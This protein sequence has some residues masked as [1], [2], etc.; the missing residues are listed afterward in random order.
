M[1]P[2]TPVTGH[3]VIDDT[4]ATHSSTETKKDLR[5]RLKTLVGRMVE[6]QRAL[7]AEQKRALLVVLQGRDTAGKDGTIRKVF[8]RLNPATCR[9]TSF[10]R[11]TDREL[12][13]DYLW[14]IHA[15]VPPRG[16]IGIFN[17]SHYEDVLPVRVHQLVPEARWRQ[18]YQQINV[19]EQHL[20]DH[21]VTICKFFLHIS[22]EEQRRRL[23]SR[24]ADPRKNWKFDTGDLAERRH[25]DAYT[26][27]YQE[28][29]EK[30]S[31]EYAPWY[32]VPADRKAVRDVCVAQVVVDALEGM[33]PS[34]P[35]ADPDVLA[36]KGKII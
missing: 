15:A 5:A 19:F 33:A 1:D 30:C 21:D 4:A 26:E 8:G 12:S 3:P 36:H 34:Y 2:L 24:L 14:R 13:H 27:A 10:K 31:T 11:P 20:A 22:R 28:A 32:V 29:L 18:R 17:R 23:E 9:V 16:W 7:G 6:L 35:A 25:W